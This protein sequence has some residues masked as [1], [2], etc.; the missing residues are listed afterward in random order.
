MVHESEADWII[1]G[2]HP[3]QCMWHRIPG[4]DDWENHGRPMQGAQFSHSACILCQKLRGHVCIWQCMPKSGW[5]WWVEVSQRHEGLISYKIFPRFFFGSCTQDVVNFRVMVWRQVWKC[6][7]GS[8]MEALPLVNINAFRILEEIF[9][10]YV[11]SMN[12]RCLGM[13]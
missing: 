9:E 4:Q 13:R 12:S 10:H 11:F 1:T 8:H 3:A 7:H 6:F 2:E 5:E